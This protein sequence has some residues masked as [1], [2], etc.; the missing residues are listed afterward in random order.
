MHSI[1][2]EE[3]KHGLLTIFLCPMGFETGG[4]DMWSDVRTLVY[5]AER[6]CRFRITMDIWNIID[7]HSSSRGTRGLSRR[8]SNSPSPAS[9]EKCFA[10]FWKHVVPSLCPLH[11]SAESDAAWHPHS[12]GCIISGSPKCPLQDITVS[13]ALTIKGQDLSM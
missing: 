6:F 2:S 10:P 7:S 12:T 3:V 11:P 8:E 13:T 9:C 1:I 5:Q 4:R